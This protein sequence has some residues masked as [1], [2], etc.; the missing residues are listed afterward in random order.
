MIRWEEDEQSGEWRGFSGDLVVATVK[1]D[2][3]GGNT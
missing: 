2:Q 3:G 1:R